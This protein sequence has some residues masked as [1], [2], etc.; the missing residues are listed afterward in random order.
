MAVLGGILTSTLQEPGYLAQSFLWQ[1]CQYFR[2]SF[3]ILP[4]DC[5]LILD[6]IQRQRVRVY[7]DI[8]VCKIHPVMG[9]NIAKKKEWSVSFVISLQY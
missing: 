1:C 7:V 3:H 4:N 9:R 5:C 8:F 2:G 6:N